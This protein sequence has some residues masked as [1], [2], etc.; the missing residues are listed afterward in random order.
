MNGC[1]C[2]NNVDKLADVVTVQT[3]CRGKVGFRLFERFYFRSRYQRCPVHHPSLLVA[4]SRRLSPLPD[5]KNDV[6]TDVTRPRPLGM[7]N[8]LGLRRLSVLVLFVRLGRSAFSSAFYVPGCEHRSAE[9]LYK[10]VERFRDQIHCSELAHRAQK[11]AVLLSPFRSSLHPGWVHCVVVRV[12]DGFFGP[13]PRAGAR[14][15]VLG[16]G[17]WTE[18]AAQRQGRV[19]EKQRPQPRPATD[20][21]GQLVLVRNA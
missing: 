14:Q 13:R 3:Y 15:A 2:I 21:A 4:S 19:P 16:R 7:R 1:I 10:Y 17:A 11:S 18:E 6:T 5:T 8:P 20:Q 12:F 9:V